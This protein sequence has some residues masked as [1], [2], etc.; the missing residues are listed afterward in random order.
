MTK[1]D[2]TIAKIQPLCTRSR[3]EARRRQNSLTKPKGSLGRLEELSVILAGIQRT[4]S[5]VIREKVILTMA[6]DHGV[7]DEVTL[8]PREVTVQQVL[9]FLRG[10]GGVNVLARH[11]GARVVLV[12]MELP[13]IS[14]LRKG[15]RSGKL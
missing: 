8:Y 10:G 1:L 7:V 6:G 9:N 11:V 15:C 3:E 14:N 4:S 13:M 5:P 12:D 2:Q